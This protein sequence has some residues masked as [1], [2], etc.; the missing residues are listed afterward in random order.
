MKHLS[1]ALIVITLLLTPLIIWAEHE[2]K[3]VYSERLFSPNYAFEPHFH[4]PLYYQGTFLPPV[5]NKNVQLTPEDNPVIVASPVLVYPEAS[6]SISPGTRLYFHE[7]TLLKIEGQLNANGSPYHPV[8]FSTN[9]V[10]PKNKTWGGIIAS[11]GSQVDINHAHFKHA[12]V[13]L[14]CLPES[15][16]TISNSTI[17]SGSVGIYTTTDNCHINNSLIR[18]IRDGIVSI[19]ASPS[20]NNTTVSASRDQVRNIA[21]STIP[22]PSL[23]SN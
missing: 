16:A 19:N 7:F 5:I 21:N 20:I 2:N 15:I 8:L 23:S 13:S 10:N 9:E 3:K 22:T 4:T 1:T 12:A 14:S 18:K 6:L 17:K 11:S